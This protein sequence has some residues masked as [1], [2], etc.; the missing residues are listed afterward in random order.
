MEAGSTAA[1][2]DAADAFDGGDAAT[3]D[4]GTADAANDAHRRL[5][6]SLE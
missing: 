3:A 6:A 1:T 5:D 2:D 4:G